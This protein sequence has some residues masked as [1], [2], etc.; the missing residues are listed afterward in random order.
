MFMLQIVEQFLIEHQLPHWKGRKR[1]KPTCFADEEMAHIRMLA[2]LCVQLDISSH[3]AGMGN[4][5]GE[6]VK[7]FAL[8]SHS[9][10]DSHSDFTFGP[11][12]S[13]EMF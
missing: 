4:R 7:G 6:S 13:A 2:A 5:V 3:T 12:R 10:L 11:L 1:L 8:D 9:E